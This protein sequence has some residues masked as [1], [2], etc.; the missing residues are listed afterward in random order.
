MC[1]Q[2]LFVAVCHLKREDDSAGV[3]SRLGNTVVAMRKTENN[4]EGEQK[5]GP[6]AS[7]K[8]W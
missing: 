6:A 1:L 5:T 8:Y 7:S 3:E 4:G 2:F